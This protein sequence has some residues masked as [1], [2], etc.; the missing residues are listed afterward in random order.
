[1]HFNGTLPLDARCVY[2]LKGDNQKRTAVYSRTFVITSR[3]NHAEKGMISLS[4]VL[5][6]QFHTSKELLL[7]R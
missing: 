1:M 4:T 5:S 6:F 2:T 7:A 3:D